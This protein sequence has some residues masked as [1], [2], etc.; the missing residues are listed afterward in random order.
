M[1]TPTTSTAQD[2]L[3]QELI[4]FSNYENKIPDIT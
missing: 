3:Y 1:S 2:M 4:K